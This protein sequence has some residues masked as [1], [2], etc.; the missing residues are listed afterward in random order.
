MLFDHVHAGDNGAVLL[1]A[2][3]AHLALLTLILTGDHKH[4]IVLFELVHQTTSG[5]NDTI[6]MKF[7]SRSSRATGPKMRVPRGFCLC[8]RI[9]AALSSKRMYEPSL[10]PYCLRVRTITACTT[11]PFLM[12]LFGCVCLTDATM[13]SP[14]E[15]YRRRDPPGTRMHMIAFAPELAATFSRVYCW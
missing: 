3:F 5:A 11:S 15:A 6:F 4:R 10:R 13:T 12:L 8:V 9:T 14:T 7:F 2:H 1:G